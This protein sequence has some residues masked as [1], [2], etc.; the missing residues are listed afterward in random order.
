MP[1]LSR[2]SLNSRMSPGWQLSAAQIAASVGERL[3]RA[4]AVFR[5]GRVAGGMPIFAD[6]WLKDGTGLATI[7]AH[8]LDDR[9]AWAEYDS[10]FSVRGDLLFTRDAGRWPDRKWESQGAQHD[11][12]KRRVSA[13]VPDGATAWYFTLTDFRGLIVSSEHQ[14]SG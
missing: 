8:G 12:A 2:L 13:T 3:A 11:T 4:V 9:T 7:T 5:I 14:T 6:R 10:P 1:S